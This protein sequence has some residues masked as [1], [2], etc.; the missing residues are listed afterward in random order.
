[1]DGSN[2]LDSGE[3]RNWPLADLRV[4]EILAYL[5]SALHPKAV[6]RQ[7]QFSAIRR[8]A[9]GQKPPIGNFQN[10]RQQTHMIL[11]GALCSQ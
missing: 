3:Y 1:V 9:L 8:A 10:H 11:I 7:V 5:T 2:L 6:I 4:A